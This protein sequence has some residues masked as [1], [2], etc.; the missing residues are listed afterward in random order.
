[1]ALQAEIMF[2]CH[3]DMDPS[4]EIKY[5]SKKNR[6]KETE[7]ERSEKRSSTPDY[8]LDKRR[9]SKVSFHRIYLKSF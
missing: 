9:G 2:L 4:L 6:E 7:T 1:M 5:R 8:K 3:S